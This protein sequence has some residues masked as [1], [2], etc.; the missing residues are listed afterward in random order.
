MMHSMLTGSH[1]Q[2]ARVFI[3]LFCSIFIIQQTLYLYDRSGVTRS[4]TFLFLLPIASWSNPSFYPSTS[5]LIW[6]RHTPFIPDR[7]VSQHTHL[8]CLSHLRITKRIYLP[9]PI[10]FMFIPLYVCHCNYYIISLQYS[11]GHPSCVF[12]SPVKALCFQPF[13]AL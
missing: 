4:T 12:L 6:P 5:S 9:Y 1:Y 10:I 7:W 13:K 3:S 8:H 11:T 2:Q